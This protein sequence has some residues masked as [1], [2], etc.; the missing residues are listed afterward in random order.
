M[1][2]IAARL[3]DAVGGRRWWTSP[4]AV[5]TASGLAQRGERPEDTVFARVAARRLAT[6]NPADR[7]ALETAISEVGVDRD[8]IERATASGAPIA[9]IAGLAARWESLPAPARA[10]VRSPLKAGSV[11]QVKWGTTHAIQVDQTTCG[12]ASLSIMAM[13]T[14]PF[15]ALWVA[16]GQSIAPYMPPEVLNVETAGLPAHTLEDRWVALQR[17]LHV[18]T[19][20]SAVGPLP[21]PRSFGTPPWRVDNVARCA[22]IKFRGMVV[23]DADGAD[24]AAAIA[25]SS[26]SLRD[27][28]PVPMYVGGDSS[29]GVGTA[30]P[31]HVVLLV[32]RDGDLF[33]HLR[34]RFR[35]GAQGRDSRPVT[36][37]RAPRRAWQLVAHCVARVA[38]A[39]RVVPESRPPRQLLRG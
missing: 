28:I 23:D 39:S 22:G 38:E 12:A 17:V 7:K 37:A 6:A 9:A 11:G 25:H 5:A 33:P 24:L 16:T 18:A 21:W 1:T 8:V 15:V 31:R 32:G 26:A 4:A 35:C 13:I 10:V 20:R 34:A 14:D 30:V 2:A 36:A 29:L 19:T 27:G 3:A